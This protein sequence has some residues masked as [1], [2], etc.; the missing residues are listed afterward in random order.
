MGLSY[1]TDTDSTASDRGDVMG[2]FRVYQKVDLNG[3]KDDKRI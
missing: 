1:L 2:Y 3:G